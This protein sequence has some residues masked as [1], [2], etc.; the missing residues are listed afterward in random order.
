M[1]LLWV[2]SG[3]YQLALEVEAKLAL[4]VLRNSWMF[5][6]STPH[7]NLKPYT[8]VII[9]KFEVHKNSENSS[10]KMVLEINPHALINQLVVWAV[11][12][13]E[14]LSFVSKI[15]QRGK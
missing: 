8:E 15:A 6:V 3:A 7:P 11:S 10:P 14:K 4:V 1:H 5:V 9:Q 2:L 12:S 13:V